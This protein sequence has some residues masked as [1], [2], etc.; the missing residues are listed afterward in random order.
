MHTPSSTAHDPEGTPLAV[1]RLLAADPSLTQREL[2]RALG[3]SLGKTHYVLHAL[4]ARGLV[5]IRNFQRSDR[6]VAY[7]YLLTP[8][9]LR[10][11]LRLTRSFLSRKET[12]F[13]QLQVT[14]A[15]LRAELARNIEEHPRQG[16]RCLSGNHV[17][18]AEIGDARG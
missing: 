14:I 17:L 7:A 1:L 3:M 6:K 4:L 16:N 13:E 12:E 5:K 10:E 15:E 8:A 11:K 9:G 2:S 18:S